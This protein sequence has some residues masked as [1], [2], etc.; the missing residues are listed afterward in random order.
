MTKT[1]AENI[2][3]TF[4]MLY[5]LAILMIVDG[6]IGS[7]DYLSFN[8]LFPYQNYHIALF[9]FVSGYFINLKRTYKEFIT[10]KFMKLIVPLYVWNFIYG[11]IVFCLNKYNGFNLGGEFSLYNLLYAPI[12][13]GHQFIYN[14]GSWFIVPLFGVQLIGF[15]IL[16]PLNEEKNAYPSSFI[17]LFFLLS[18][19]LGFVTIQAAP[20]NLGERNI[21]LTGF[22]IFYFLPFYALGVLYRF[23]LKKYDTLNSI[24][25]FFIIIAATV[26]LRINF[27]DCDIIPAWLDV[28]NAP[29]TIIFAIGFLAVFFWLRIAKISAPVLK[30]SPTLTYLSTHTFDI[31][32]HH[33]AGFMLVKA[34]LS[35][36]GNFDAVSFKNNIW[37]YHFPFNENFIAPVYI[38]ITIVIAL[39]TGFTSR[40]IYRILYNIKNVRQTFQKGSLDYEKQSKR[41]FND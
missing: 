27:P 14:M 2:D 8:G 16:K 29:A 1:Q 26:F 30:A 39:F 20:E 4:R 3:F 5:V 10:Y 12:A 11:L 35:P 37:Y 7:F 23:Q 13:D 18:C 6:H 17:I 40:K 21:A 28:V 19:L 22:R 31:M 25:Y 36:L 32:M 9:V 41:S 33:F 34:T 24:A 38:F 15:C